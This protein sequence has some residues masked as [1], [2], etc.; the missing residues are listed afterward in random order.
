MKK[1][2]KELSRSYILLDTQ[3]EL[4][5]TV[6]I[7]CRETHRNYYMCEGEWS[8]FVKFYDLKYGDYL[9][10]S[11]IDDN[12]F[13]VLPYGADCCP[14]FSSSRRR[15]HDF[16]QSISDDDGDGDGDNEEDEDD[17]VIHK[18]RRSAVDSRTNQNQNN[19][20]NNKTKKKIKVEV[21]TAH[22]KKSQDFKKSNVVDSCPLG[23]S[24]RSKSGDFFLV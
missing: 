9:L 5:W 24:S 20:N 2:S 23:S 15:N 11:L 21:G 4:S 17:R 13:K 22:S 19:N 6:K 18:R 3:A 16:H 1:Y 8:F 12:V 10:F 14:K 7:R